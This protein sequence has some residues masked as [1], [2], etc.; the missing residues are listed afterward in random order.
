MPRTVDKDAQVM[1]IFKLVQVA[2]NISSFEKSWIYHLK[3]NPVQKLICLEEL[4]EKAIKIKNQ[5][6][7]QKKQTGCKIKRRS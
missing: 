7:N 1:A 5:K 2:F 3:E 6:G 4:K